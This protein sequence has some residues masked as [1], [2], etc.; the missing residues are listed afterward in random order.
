M[1]FYGAERKVDVSIDCQGFESCYQSN[2]E[3]ANEQSLYIYA[4]GT[5]S[6]KSMGYVTFYF[7][8]LVYL[9]QK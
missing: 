6:A 4:Q 7:L 1:R 9:T 3:C 8:F 5:N 2:V